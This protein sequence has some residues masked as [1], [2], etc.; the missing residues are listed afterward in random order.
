MAI[1]EFGGVPQAILFLPVF[2]LRLRSS[3][4]MPIFNPM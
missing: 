3:Y 2:V 1:D 4:W